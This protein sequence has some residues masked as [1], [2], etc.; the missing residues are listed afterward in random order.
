MLGMTYHIV[1]VPII[2]NK[3]KITNTIRILNI[4]FVYSAI[5]HVARQCQAL[6]GMKNKMQEPLPNGL[7]ILW[8]THSKFVV[9]VICKQKLNILRAYLVQGV[10]YL[11]YDN[12][13]HDGS[14]PQ[15][16]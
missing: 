10:D 5:E 2:H 16:R 6:L 14:K 11:K 7:A 1:T 13:Y 3:L 15:E 4:Y 8:F 9:M 12:C